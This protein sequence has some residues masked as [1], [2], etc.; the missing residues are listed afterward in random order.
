MEKILEFEEKRAAK[1]DKLARDVTYLG[2]NNVSF[3]SLLIPY[4]WIEQ[5]V[6]DARKHFMNTALQTTMS[7]VKPKIVLSRRSMWPK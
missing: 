1:S 7:D 3:Y 4:K 2:V 5:R 6:C